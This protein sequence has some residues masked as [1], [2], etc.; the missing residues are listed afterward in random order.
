MKLPYFPFYVGD[1]LLK[2]GELTHAEVGAYLRLLIYQWSNGSLNGDPNRLPINCAN[3]WPMIEQYFPICDDGRRRNSRLED[4]RI[5]ISQLREN[6]RL[7]GIKGANKRWNLGDDTNGDPNGDPNGIPESE[8]EP[9]PKIKPKKKN[10]APKG[11]EHY[12]SKNGLK[13]WG[14]SLKAF[15]LF[16]KTFNYPH[17][18]A[19]TIDPWV[20]LVGNGDDIDEKLALEIIAGA[21]TEASDRV[22]ILERKGT[23][24]WAQGWLTARRWEDMQPKAVSKP[25]P[26]EKPL[27]AEEI[28]ENEKLRGNLVADFDKLQQHG[29]EK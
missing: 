20:K 29:L 12:N 5:K 13:L 4:E 1:F 10:T 14:R 23:P 9:K 17:G 21:K 27:T 2:T 18:R 15:K 28:A 6:Q 11:A 19:A 25:K 24:I 8:S 7:A 22:E 16:W 3:E 26:I